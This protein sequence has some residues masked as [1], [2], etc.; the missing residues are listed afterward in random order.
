MFD[1]T[2]LVLTVLVA[3]PSRAQDVEGHDVSIPSLCLDELLVAEAA[4][5]SLPELGAILGASAQQEAAI[6]RLAIHRLPDIVLI[7]EEISALH[8]ALHEFASHVVPGEV[9]ELLEDLRTHE[10]ERE[11]LLRDLARDMFAQLTLEQRLRWEA[12]AADDPDG[13]GIPGRAAEPCV[14]AP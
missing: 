6:R 8:D 2:L 1:R 9:A 4:V 10:H 7:E 3:F 14:P 13:L 11:A 12:I 5:F